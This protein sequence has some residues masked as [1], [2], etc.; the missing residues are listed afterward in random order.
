[1]LRLS[2]I[3]ILSYNNYQ[4]KKKLFLLYFTMQIQNTNKNSKRDDLSLEEYV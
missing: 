3:F 2:F 4:Y 1:M